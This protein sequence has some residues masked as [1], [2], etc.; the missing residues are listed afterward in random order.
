MLAWVS[1]NSSPSSSSCSYG[2]AAATDHSPPSTAQ[3]FSLLH[4]AQVRSKE[5]RRYEE[6]VP[7]NSNG[8]MLM[9][10][11]GAADKNVSAEN[12][13]LKKQPTIADRDIH[14][15]G[16]CADRHVKW[17]AC[18]LSFGNKSLVLAELG[19]RA[20]QT[21]RAFCHQTMSR[22]SKSLLTSVQLMLDSQRRQHGSVGWFVFAIGPGLALLVVLLIAAFISLGRHERVDQRGFANDRSSIFCS[23]ADRPRASAK[24]GSHEHAIASQ[25]ASVLG[26]SGPRGS[27]RTGDGLC[28]SSKLVA[29]KHDAKTLARSGQHVTG[30]PESDSSAAPRASGPMFLLQTSRLD[31]ACLCPMLVV[32]PSCESCL[33]L[34][35][36][37][38]EMSLLLLI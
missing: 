34:P 7:Q 13:A 26:V 32:P 31:G 29:E 37:V 8:P 6:D 21:A 17:H 24:F 5:A 2:P 4:V 14:A 19:L 10:G 36:K 22:M 15:E 25:R 1:V 3:S 35:A 12:M 33:R 27:L 18:L 20:L 28:A 11:S 30:V 16:P 23:I 9:Q 38:R